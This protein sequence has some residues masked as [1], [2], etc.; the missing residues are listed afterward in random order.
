MKVPIYMDYH[1][2]T[3]LDPRVLEAMLPYFREE[4]GNAA[5]KSH[6]FGWRAEEA[7]EAA[8]TEIG[9]F[10]GAWLAIEENDQVL[11]DGVASFPLPIGAMPGVPTARKGK[12]INDI[13]T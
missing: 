6:V 7:V 12:P 1:A 10:I 9:S 13:S 5:S 2:T 8:R 4:L 3:P 11:A